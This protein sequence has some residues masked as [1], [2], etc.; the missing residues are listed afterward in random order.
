MECD[1]AEVLMASVQG[2][3]DEVHIEWK[4]EATICVV[5]CS[6][7]YPDKTEFGKEI[8][9]LEEAGKMQDVVLFHAGVQRENGKLYTAGGRVIG[10]TA[11]NHNLARAQEQVYNAISKIHFD[12]MHYRKDIASKALEHFRH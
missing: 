11:S 6:K 12:G 1:L 10:V 4:K 3:L 5:L 9:G 8:V 7:G 2:R